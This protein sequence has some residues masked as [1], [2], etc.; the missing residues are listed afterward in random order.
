MHT[1]ATSHTEVGL[2]ILVKGLDAFV[3]E[4]GVLVGI[5]TGVKGFCNE[6]MGRFPVIFLTLKSVAFNNFN[7]SYSELARVIS[8]L[9]MNFS[10]LR[11]SS[12]LE[13][14]EKAW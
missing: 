1:L 11:Y 9:A 8:S 10:Y 13:T 5:G 2:R 6:F 4:R 12:E 3:T 14:E 7:D